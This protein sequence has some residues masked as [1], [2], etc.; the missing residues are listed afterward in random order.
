ME[1]LPRKYFERLVENSL[2]IVVATDRHGKVVFYSDGGRKSLG[3]AREEVLD[4][5]VVAFYPS[6]EEAR[7][8]MEAMRGDP[9]GRIMN[10]ETIF[11]AKNG[12]HV[13]VSITGAIIHDDGGAEIGSIGFAKDLRE[14]RRKDQLATLG[15]I[16][17]G[18]SHEINNPLTVIWNNLELISKAL[19]GKPAED[20]VSRRIGTIRTEVDRIRMRIE[21][22]ELMARTG[23]YAS[24][25]YLRGAQ[26]IDLVAA[27][28]ENARAGESAPAADLRGLRVLVVDDDPSVTES[29]REILGADGC[30]V[31]TAGSAEEALEDIDDARYDLILSD[32]VMPNMDGYDLFLKVRES[33]PDTAMILMT[34]YYYDK[35]HIIKRSKLE[36]LKGS[37]FKKPLNPDHLRTVIASVCHR[38]G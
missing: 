33:C 24:K 22:V 31:K 37:V 36:G 30:E 3:Y 9:G 17:V 14:I 8:V 29:L 7:K 38:T 23:V 20:E 27:S 10:F 18:L 28:A 21:A 25:E 1:K 2:D 16:A 6:E 5:H 34:G 12:E 26:M 19:S 13:P 32:V 4:R 15:E 35:D 11:V